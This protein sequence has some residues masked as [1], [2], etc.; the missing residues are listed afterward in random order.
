MNIDNKNFMLTVNLAIFKVD[1]TA[2]ANVKKLPRRE[3]S[4]LLT[5]RKREPFKGCRA[6]PYRFVGIG[7]SLDDAVFRELGEKTTLQNLYFEQ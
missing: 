7:E 3:L 4:V 5:K 1:E 6:F 2:R